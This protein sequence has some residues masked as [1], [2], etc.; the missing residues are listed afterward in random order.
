MHSDNNLLNYDNRSLHGRFPKLKPLTKNKK[1]IGTGKSILR[2][3][4]KKILIKEVQF[5]I[6]IFQVVMVKEKLLSLEN[7]RKA[8][9]FDFKNYF[10]E[11]YFFLNL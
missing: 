3:G 11:H 9:Y 5:L 1:Y 8:S 7:L 6:K 10:I 4:I 2:G